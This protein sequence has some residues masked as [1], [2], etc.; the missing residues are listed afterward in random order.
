[1]WEH[2]YL[3]GGAFVSV[4]V[5]SMVRWWHRAGLATYQFAPTPLLV[6]LPSHGWVT[7]WPRVHWCIRGMVFMALIGAMGQPRT[8]ITESLLPVKGIS[9]MLLLDVSRSMECFD[10]IRDQTTRFT[11]AQR[12][13]RTFVERRPS[14]AIGLVMFGAVAATR[15]PLTH[16][17]ALLAKILNDTSIGVVDE[18]RTVLAEAI[19]MGVR[20][21]HAVTAGAK[22]IVL[23][24]DGEPSPEDAQRLPEAIEHAQCEQ[25]KI[26]TIGMGN[27]EGGFMR[28]PMG[29]IVR[30]PSGVQ[31]D[32]LEQIA[33]ATGG[34][35]F[36]ARNQQ[37][38]Q[39]I[40]ATIDSLERIEIE[41]PEYGQWYEWGLWLLAIA[42]G[43]VCVEL[44]IVWWHM[45]L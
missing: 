22:V 37:E 31:S 10:D 38:L 39:N 15:C 2:P 29:G 42:M 19:I 27:P 26:Y 13:A 12:E 11:A 4:L 5:I 17:H 20:R 8:P 32:L 25:V 44:G 7:W 23:L 40:Y 1:M 35:H 28:H 24:T 30:L 3:M 41:R 14:D 6:D 36:E 18:S 43:M 16:D 21:L 9:I 33:R 45:M 34:R